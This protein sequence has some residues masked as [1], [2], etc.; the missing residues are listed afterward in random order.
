MITVTHRVAIMIR[1]STD[2]VVLKT[3]SRT[4]DRR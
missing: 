1:I 4:Y 3:Q 2:G